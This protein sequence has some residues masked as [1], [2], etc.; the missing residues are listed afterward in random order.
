MSSDDSKE[1]DDELLASIVESLS[2]NNDW[3][4]RNIA[5]F[6][7]TSKECTRNVVQLDQF[8]MRVQ[9][10]MS[11]VS[12][13]CTVLST[14]T[15]ILVL[16]EFI[17]TILEPAIASSD[18]QLKTLSLFIL[19]LASV[20]DTVMTGLLSY[21]KAE[22]WDDK[23]RIAIYCRQEY[24]WLR[25]QIDS[26]LYRRSKYRKSAR[27]FMEFITHTKHRIT[28]LLS[29]TELV[30]IRLPQP[31]RVLKEARRLS[32]NAAIIEDMPTMFLKNSDSDSEEKTCDT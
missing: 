8:I 23:L 18:I 10:Q 14:I 15:N 22:K 27:E 31:T 1:Y 25:D 28:P 12:T 9:R 26:Q 11:I 17:R 2:G 5:Y 13:I 21:Q 3:T 20:L 29:D 32:D 6:L 7:N 16:I 19:A 4:E 24:Q 30:P